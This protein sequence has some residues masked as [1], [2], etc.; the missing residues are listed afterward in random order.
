MHRRMMIEQLLVEVQTKNI[1]ASVANINIGRHER[2]DMEHRRQKVIGHS[3]QRTKLVHW[4]REK[5]G[6]K[7]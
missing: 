1:W 4:A 5:E 2:R 7:R 3:R 6:W